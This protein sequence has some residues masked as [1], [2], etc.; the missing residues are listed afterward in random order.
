[1]TTLVNMLTNRLSSFYRLDGQLQQTINSYTLTWAMLINNVE[2]LSV[3]G[4]IEVQFIRRPIEIP[5]IRHPIGVISTR[6]AR[7]VA[8]STSEVSA[9]PDFVRVN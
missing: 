5:S 1:M 9:A 3:R 7:L 2:V 8:V 4:E 6:L